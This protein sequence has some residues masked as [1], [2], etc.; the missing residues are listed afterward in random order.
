MPK[1]V[2]GFG[3]V[4]EREPA[5]DHLVVGVPV[6]LD[7]LGVGEV[8]GN[9]RLEHRGDRFAGGEGP[10]YV[11]VEVVGNVDADPGAEGGT[12]LDFLVGAREIVGILGQDV[13]VITQNEVGAFGV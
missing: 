6:D 4:H 7:P 12:G 8:A 11:E 13:A 10:Q 1:K 5:L 9:L 2:A 3:V